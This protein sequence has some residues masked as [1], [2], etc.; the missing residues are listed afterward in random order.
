MALRPGLQ[1]P[2]VGSNKGL[3]FTLEIAKITVAA[4]H[5]GKRSAR[6]QTSNGASGSTITA[7]AKVRSPFS[8]E[9]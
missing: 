4:E 6:S 2:G 5:D 7:V 9:A 8:T 3:V 1:L